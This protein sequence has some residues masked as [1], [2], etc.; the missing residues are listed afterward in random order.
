MSN[1]YVQSSSDLVCRL[2]VAGSERKIRNLPLQIVNWLECAEWS[3]R[4]KP[5]TYQDTLLAL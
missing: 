4:G 5:V 2:K 3:L 1:M